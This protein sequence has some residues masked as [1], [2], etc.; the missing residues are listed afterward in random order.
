MDKRV[1]QSQ[2]LHFF[3]RS[4]E[5]KYVNKAWCYRGTMYSRCKGRCVWYRIK[6]MMV[7]SDT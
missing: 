1:I 6:H 2:E 4:K 7:F 3:L 5:V